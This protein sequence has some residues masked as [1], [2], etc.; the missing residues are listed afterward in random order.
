MPKAELL[1]T[2][3]VP[4]SS[5]SPPEKVFPPVAAVLLA[6]SVTSDVPGDFGVVAITSACGVAPSEIASA[7]VTLP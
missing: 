2:T 5:T 3:A 6:E 4:D 7:K 1:V